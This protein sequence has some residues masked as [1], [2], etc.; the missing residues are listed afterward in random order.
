MKN[1]IGRHVGFDLGT[2]CYQQPEGVRVLHE[3]VPTMR[4]PVCARCG[5]VFLVTYSYVESCGFDPLFL[6][7][8]ENAEI[9]ARIK[10]IDNPVVRERLR[11]MRRNRRVGVQNGYKWPWEP[12]E[13]EALP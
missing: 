1:H 5:S 8:P 3:N 10:R 9:A 12:R 11:E 6:C 4:H 13:P 2:Y 7:R